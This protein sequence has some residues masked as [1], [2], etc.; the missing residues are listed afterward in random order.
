[1]DP[2]PSTPISVHCTVVNVLKGTL[3]LKPL[4]PGQ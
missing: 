1:M 4:L 3:N 2:K